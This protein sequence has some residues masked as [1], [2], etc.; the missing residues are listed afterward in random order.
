MVTSGGLPNKRLHPTGFS[1]PFIVNLD[2]LAVV[3]RRVNRS[4]R[5]LLVYVKHFDG[6]RFK[7]TD[8]LKN[9][10]TACTLYILLLPTL[11]FFGFY[12]R[13]GTS[14]NL[15]TTTASHAVAYSKRSWTGESNF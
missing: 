3:S 12:P 7:E 4:V 6:L 2:D 8:G 10:E 11:R 9:Y 13:T 15:T 1:L 14:C 5:H